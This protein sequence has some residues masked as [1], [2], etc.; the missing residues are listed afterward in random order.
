MCSV[1]AQMEVGAVISSYQP[2]RAIDFKMGGPP[3]AIIPL[4]NIPF[5]FGWIYHHAQMLIAFM[6]GRLSSP[7]PPCQSIMMSSTH[8]PD[9]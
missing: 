9:K 1:A 6:I 4:V 3:P 8:R 2:L 7:G 5:N